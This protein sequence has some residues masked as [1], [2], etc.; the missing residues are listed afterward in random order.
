MESGFDLLYLIVTVIFGVL[1][2]RNAK[3]RKQFNIFS[4]MTF[5]LVGG[6]AF[7]LVPR[8]WALNHGGVENYT[9]SLGFGTFVTSITMTIFYLLLFQFW[10]IRY[11]KRAKRLTGVMYVLSGLRIFLCFLPQNAW[12]RE[13]G[14]TT[15]WGTIRNL[16]FI[17]MGMI[18]IG[19][20]YQTRG[21][22]SFRFMWI[23]II[24]SFVFY[25]AVVL[26]VKAF[27]KMGMLML[28]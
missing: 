12:L 24:I 27:P 21:D 6:D 11:H 15:G 18:M 20:F 26:F 7:H 10:K 14:A 25:L 23:A 19:L 28:P 9:A 17:A 13:G 2:L 5:V 3:G 16:P 8:V 1:T 4:I 22:L